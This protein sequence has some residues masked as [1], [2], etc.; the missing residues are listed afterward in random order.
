MD[1]KG[2]GADRDA[3]VG[4][5]SPAY[6]CSLVHDLGDLHCQGFVTA[7]EQVLILRNRPLDLVPHRALK[8]EFKLFPLE[9]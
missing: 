7:I 3:G 4:V 9:L 6:A 5:G 2:K 8:G 1:T